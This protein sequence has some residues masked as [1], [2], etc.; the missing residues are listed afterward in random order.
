MERKE[1]AHILISKK[2][3]PTIYIIW[4]W[5][6]RQHIMEGKHTQQHFCQKYWN[7]LMYITV[8][9]DKVVTFWDIEY[10]W[11]C[12]CQSVNIPAGLK[13]PQNHSMH[14]CLPTRRLLHYCHI[15]RPPVW[16]AAVQSHQTHSSLSMDTSRWATRQGLPTPLVLQTPTTK[17]NCSTLSVLQQTWQE[18][19]WSLHSWDNHH[20]NK[21]RASASGLIALFVLWIFH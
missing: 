3:A 7:W 10:I 9:W 19:V 5:N 17:Y 20:G 1:I 2:S 12:E 13:A 21:L 4:N 16:F 18:V 14:A 11:F 8:Q 6:A 15:R